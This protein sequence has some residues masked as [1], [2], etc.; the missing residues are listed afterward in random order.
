M[1]RNEYDP[2]QLALTHE[3]GR[4]RNDALDARSGPASGA[5]QGSVPV[6]D[7]S[8]FEGARS[9]VGVVVVELG[10]QRLDLLIPPAACDPLLRLLGWPEGVGEVKTRNIRWGLPKSPHARRNEQ[11]AAAQA[12]IAARTKRMLLGG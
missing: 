4:G 2:S 12:Q 1:R 3:S 10:Q 9:G 7:R 6:G 8:R 5:H 11:Q